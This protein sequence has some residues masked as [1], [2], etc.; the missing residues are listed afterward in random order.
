MLVTNLTNIHEDTVQ[1]LAPL[2]G[3]R[4]WHCCELWCSSRHGSDLALLWLW[5]GPAAAALIRSLAWE[6]PCAE[7]AALKKFFLNERILK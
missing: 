1:S 4:I 6:I 3:L 5:S 2:S 7:G